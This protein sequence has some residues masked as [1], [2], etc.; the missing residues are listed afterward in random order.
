MKCVCC[1]EKFVHIPTLALE[2]K[3]GY[4]K[5]AV[6]KIGDINRAI[7]SVNEDRGSPYLAGT[8]YGIRFGVIEGRNNVKGFSEWRKLR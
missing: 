1:S 8:D 3:G 7:L 5:K 4:L 2:D 6:R